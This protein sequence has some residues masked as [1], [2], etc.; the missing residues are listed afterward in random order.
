M[1]DFRGQSVEFRGVGLGFDAGGEGGLDVRRFD[2][3]WCGGS[4]DGRLCA[5]EDLSESGDI[6]TPVLI[7]IIKSRSSKC[8]SA[9]C[10][11]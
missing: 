7:Y 3:V 6:K 8:V 1:G 10:Q 9:Y 11:K 4:V 2:V 5:E